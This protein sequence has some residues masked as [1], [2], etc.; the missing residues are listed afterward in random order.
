MMQ[1]A[2]NI[3]GASGGCV[4]NLI[5]STFTLNL[6]SCIASIISLVYVIY[7]SSIRHNTDSPAVC[8][9]VVRQNSVTT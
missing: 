7:V 1:G 3:R 9:I 4:V 6:Y 8:C 2:V 5:L